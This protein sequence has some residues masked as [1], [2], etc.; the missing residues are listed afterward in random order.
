MGLIYA[1]IVLI[2]PASPNIPTAVVKYAAALDAKEPHR[3]GPADH[4]GR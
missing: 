1:V 3:T 4:P 2:N